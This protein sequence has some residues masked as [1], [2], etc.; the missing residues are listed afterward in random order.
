[1][2]PHVSEPST[3]IIPVSAESLVYAMRVIRLVRSRAEP[4]VVVQLCRN[5]LRFE[6]FFSYPEKLPVETGMRTDRHLQRPS[7]QS[8]LHQLLQRFDRSAQSIELVCKTEP[9]IQAEH[10]SVLLYGLH[11]TL[12]FTDRTRHRLFT[13]DVFPGFS[14]LDRHDTMPMRWSG[15]V[16]NINIR[17]QNQ[18]AEIMISGYFFLHQFLSQFKVIFINVTN[19][20]QTCTG[21]IDMASSH[22]SGTNNTFSQLIT[23]SDI[24]ISQYVTRHNRKERN[25]SKSFQKTSSACSHSK[26]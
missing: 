3:V 24:P 16:H 9:C 10:T 12:S 1:M 18:I 20:N 4:H 21:I 17:V 15:D 6:I 13:P 25:P 7:Q 5:R 8:A 23:R 26:L 19:G 2:L 11:H 22:P 14:G